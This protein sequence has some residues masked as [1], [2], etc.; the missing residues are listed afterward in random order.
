MEIK[1]SLPATLEPQDL[2][3]FTG[4][5]SGEIDGCRIVVADCSVQK[6]DAWFVIE[7]LSTNDLSCAVPKG[8]VH[9]LSAETAWGADKFLSPHKKAFLGQ[10]DRL[11]TFYKTS[12]K[13]ASFASPFLPWM[14]NANHG[15]VLRP[16]SRDIHFLASLDSLPKTQKLSMFC[17]SQT[18]KPEHRRRLEFAKVAKAYFG[19]DLTWFGNGIN[20]VEEKWEGLAPFERTIVLENTVQK[21]VFSEKIY[22]PF[23]A[24]CQPIYSG[25]PDICEYFPIEQKQILDL[26]DFGLSIK[27]IAKLLEEEVTDRDRELLQIGKQT[28]L[29]QHHFLRRICRIAKM[30]APT[31]ANSRNARDR[32]LRESSSFQPA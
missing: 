13:R 25:A 32:K 2:S 30:N 31:R 16:H 27:R 3:Q 28:V 23:L 10:F 20:E 9:F 18:W 17:S 14:I 29:N 5:V 24:L 22:D 26:A 21:G 1:I 11:H 15:T 12:H 4:N 7:D 19:D 8:Q 6:A